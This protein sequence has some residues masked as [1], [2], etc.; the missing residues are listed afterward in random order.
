MD[1]EWTRARPFSSSL[2]APNGVPLPLDRQAELD[3]LTDVELELLL[4]KA[5]RVGEADG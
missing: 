1:S 5:R 4:D 3:D 2:V